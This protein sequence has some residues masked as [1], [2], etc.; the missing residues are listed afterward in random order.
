MLHET[1]EIKLL[2]TERNL[3]LQRIYTVIKIK[4]FLFSS[5]I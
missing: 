4:A 2:K 5:L 1:V 3:L